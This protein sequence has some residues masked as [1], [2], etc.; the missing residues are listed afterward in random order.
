MP[1]RVHFG[2][3]YVLP[4]LWS[5]RLACILV[6]MRIDQ[7]LLATLEASAAEDIDA[8]AR[9][10]ERAFVSWAEAIGPATLGAVAFYF[11]GAEIEPY[12]PSDAWAHGFASAA[13]DGAR[14]RPGA[15]LFREKPAFTPRPLVALHD[16]LLAA[17]DEGRE[18][19]VEQLEGLEPRAV[20]LTIDR[21]RA[22]LE[23]ARGS[24]AFRR[25]RTSHRLL[26]AVT[27]GHDEPTV[28]ILDL[29][30]PT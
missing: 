11:A 26:F 18:A 22:A 7:E 27:P 21:V 23:T 20:E 19:D 15:R 17:Y 1:A 24:D 10:L 6:G 3:W 29:E 5:A 8:M 28:P 14:F 12:V 13:F 2:A 9:E 30:I 25:L 16:A 4:S